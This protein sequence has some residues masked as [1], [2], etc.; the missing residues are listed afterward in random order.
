[1]LTILAVIDT[2]KL[3]GQFTTYQL[4]ECSAN[5]AIAIQRSDG[6]FPPGKNGAYNQ[7]LTPVLTTSN[8]LATFARVWNLNGES[9]FRESAEAAADYLCSRGVR[10]FDKTFKVLRSGSHPT[11]RLFGQAVPIRQLAIAGRLL[12]RRDLVELANEVYELHPFCERMGLWSALDLRG[13]RLEIPFEL[14]HQLGF[15]DA[16]RELMSEFEL[17]KT[18]VDIFL[19][20]IGDVL[21]TRECGLLNTFLYPGFSEMLLTSSL[22]RVIK[23]R[24]LLIQRRRSTHQREKDLAYLPVLGEILA[25][26]NR[27]V[28]DHDLWGTADVKTPIQFIRTEEL[29]RSIKLKPPNFGSFLPAI[30]HAL[31]LSTFS[32][33]SSNEIRFWI[34]VDVHRTLDQD[35]GLLTKGT[36]DPHLQASHVYRLAELQEIKLSGDVPH[37]NEF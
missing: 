16:A 22:K 7:N 13:N 1:M 36:I 10:P 29:Q 20:G 33:A 31:A 34:E 26:L 9:R 18:H 19:D 6:S 25:K 32:E 28:P 15:A 30:S 23:N 17:A 3:G 4:L 21:R 24:I 35:P 11:L 8:W 2:S 37:I 27:S 14:H 12:G 5:A